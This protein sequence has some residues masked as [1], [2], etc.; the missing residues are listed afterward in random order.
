MR[1]GLRR[2]RPVGGCANRLR[3]RA[4]SARLRT[5]RILVD[6]RASGRTVPPPFK[7][8]LVQWKNQ[9][10]DPEKFR[11]ENDA[12]VQS[13]VKSVEGASWVIGKVE[14][15]ERRR[16]PAPPFIT[17]RCSR[18]RRASWAFTPSA[19][20]ASRSSSTKA[21]SSA[22]RTGGPDHLHAYRLDAHRAKPSAPCAVSSSQFGK[23]YVPESPIPIRTKKGAQDAHEAI[24]P[25]SLEYPPDTVRRYL[26]REEVALYTLIWN[27]FVASQM[28]PAVFDQTTVDIPAARN[29]VP[30]HRPADQVRRLHA[31]LHRGARRRADQNMTTTRT[32]RRTLTA[33]CRICK[34]RRADAA[35]MLPRQHFTQPPPR[36]SQATLIKELEEKG[37]GRPSTYASIMSTIL[38]KEYV[39]KTRAAGC[40]DR[41]RLPGDRSARRIVSRHPQRRVH[42][43]HG[44]PARRDRG[45]Q[46]EL[47]QDDEALLQA[48]RARSRAR[49]QR[50]ARRQAQEVPTDIA[51]E[52]C[53]KQMVIKWGRNGEFLACSQLPGV[54]EH[55]ELQ[56]RRRRRDRIAV[57]EDDRRGVREVRPADDGALRAL[58]QV[59]RLLRLS[60][61][62]ERSAAGK[63]VP[64]GIKCPDCNEG[65]IIERKSR[66]GKTF[67]CCNRYPDC[68]FAT[69]ERPVPSPAPTARPFIVEKTT[70]RAGRSHRCYNKDAGTRFKWPSNS[71]ALRRGRVACKGCRAR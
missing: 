66:W 9:K 26:R 11:L 8:K 24:R 40:A 36:F 49:R 20:C 55:E 5:G 4:R 44:G 64:T 19:P 60:G 14:H 35:A 29:G 54:Q 48:V 58:R 42:R 56:A 37:I 63:P 2:P 67:F 59:P 13:I 51:C 52:K 65:E 57:E 68:Q 62:Q 45:R 16:F 6:H 17:S 27:R 47:D 46:G 53:G 33:R 69:W 3:A 32:R 1:R 28:M 34:G 31:G 43:R 7:A 15:K 22:R 18:K 71:A 38:D 21:S 70:K 25:T 39:A 12:T 30:R 23:N 41:A 61:V 50:D 10:V